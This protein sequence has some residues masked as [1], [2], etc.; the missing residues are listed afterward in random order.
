MPLPPL[1]SPAGFGPRLLGLARGLAASAFLFS[2]LLGFNLLQTLSLVLRPFSPAGFRA[3]NRWGTDTWWGWCDR[4]AAGPFGIRIEISGDALPQAENAIVIAN[5]QQ[6]TD[7]T[8]LFRL[9]RRHGRLG[10]LKWFV[11]DIFKWVPGAGWGMLFLDCLFIKRDWA[12]DR[13]KIAATFA[14]LVDHRVPAWVVSFVEGTR[15][16]PA[17]LERSRTY[18]VS[19]GR[20][21]LAHLLTPRTKGFVAT[22][23]G[24][25]DHAAA[26][27]DCTIGYVAG[28]P[29]LWQWVQGHV[30]HVHLHVR[31]TALA[32]LPADEGGLTAWL[33]ARFSEK[34]AL[35]ARYY[36][37]GS[38]S[39]H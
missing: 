25:R 35:L 24:L 15:L 22:V 23:Q 18:A 13:A 28:V 2:T 7:I 6:M 20:P 17:K 4:L 32:A 39:T 1:V 31:R 12:A 34:D 8:V 9:A 30:R 19:Q 38:F 36:A 29:S 26:V 37:T 5:H 16:T 14:R 11:K 10:D 21:P 27:Y 3:F 33:H